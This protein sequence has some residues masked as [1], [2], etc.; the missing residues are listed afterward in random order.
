M[1]TARGCPHAC[2]YCTYP[3]LEGAH[4]RRRPPE[5]V[6]DEMERLRREVGATEQFIVDSSFN[7]DEGHMTA[8]CE[9]LRRRR[10]RPGAPLADVSFSCYLQPRVG[11][12]GVFRLLRAAGCTSLDFG[13]DT[14]AE[15][16]LPGLGKSFSIAGLRASTAAAKAAGIDVCHS[17]LFGGPGETPATVAESV[18]VTDEV[19]P[20]AVVAMVGLRIYPGTEARRSGPRGGPHR[21][22]P[23]PAGA[24]VLRRGV[25]RRRPGGGVAAAAG[26]RGRGRAPELVP[27]RR[28]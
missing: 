1:Q 22:A 23:G 6:A 20:T 24:A 9:E 17:L 28:A 10:S 2:V 13:I 19:A 3:G 15:A 11:D 21:R 5:A 12:P 4:L 7:A 25:P 18:R 8:V 14:A 27:P 26:E 16:L